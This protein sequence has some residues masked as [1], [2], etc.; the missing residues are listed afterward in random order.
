MLC[1]SC[2]PTAG[3]VTLCVLET[4]CVELCRVCLWDC[5]RSIAL[6]MY[7]VTCV[8]MAFY[9]RSHIKQSTCGPIAF[10]AFIRF[11]F[12]VVGSHPLAFAE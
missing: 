1:S 9:T 5:T 3:L 12:V 2:G 10:A 8:S 4:A 6:S 11:R 7:A